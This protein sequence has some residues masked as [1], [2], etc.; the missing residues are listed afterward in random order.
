MGRLMVRFWSGLVV[1]P[2]YLLG[3]GWRQPRDSALDD[4]LA[5]RRDAPAIIV[6][7]YRAAGL[8][9]RGSRHDPLPLVVPRCWR[10]AVGG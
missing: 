2:L 9:R 1:K 10:A 6:I 7:V 8:L 3:K 5:A 4:G